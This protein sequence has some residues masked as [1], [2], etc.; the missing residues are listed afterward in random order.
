MDIERFAR[1]ADS[2]TER[3]PSEFLEGLNGGI[4]VLDEAHHRPNDPKGVY[5]LAEYITDEALGA[6]IALYHGS[7]A[8]LFAAESEEVWHKELW[9]TITHELRHHVEARAG[10]GDLD[11]ED[12]IEL[13]R[14]REEAEAPPRRYRLNRPI[15]PR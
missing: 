2:M 8:K 11:L 12:E 13:E 1:I 3:I 9:E 14:F 6:Y 5:I 15:R 7:F 10:M 4:V